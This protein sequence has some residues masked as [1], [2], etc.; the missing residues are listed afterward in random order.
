[1]GWR[2]DSGELWDI[3]ALAAVDFP[4]LRIKQD[5]LIT[6]VTYSLTMSGGTVTKLELKD[7]KAFEPEPPK[8]EAGGGGKGGGKSS[9]PELQQAAA[10]TAWTA[11][12]EAAGKK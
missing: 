7:P 10:D 5:L 8:K 4:Y 3:N 12:K 11:N 6:K 1:M 2:Q 9:G